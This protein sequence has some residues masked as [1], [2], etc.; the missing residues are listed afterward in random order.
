MIL[1]SAVCSLGH[2]WECPSHEISG[3][4]QTHCR[5]ALQTA[6]LEATRQRWSVGKGG[7]EANLKFGESS[8]GCETRPPRAEPGRAVVSLA[9]R[10]A[11]DALMRRHTRV[12]AEVI[13]LETSPSQVLTASG[14]PKA[15]AASPREGEEALHVAGCQPS[16]RTKRTAQ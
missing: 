12:R 11:I 5:L 4:A 8:S 2:H 10:G 13:S 9:A 1:R 14:R 16:A 15:A 3:Q 7:G 6:D